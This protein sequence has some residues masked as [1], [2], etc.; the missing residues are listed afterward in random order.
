MNLGLKQLAGFLLM[1]VALSGCNAL[2]RIENI[3]GVPGM[4]PITDPTLDPNYKPV[5]MPIPPTSGIH[6]A[7]SL[8]MAGSHSFFHDPRASHVGDVITVD[9]T[10]ADNAQGSNTTTRARQNADS[11]NMTNFFGLENTLPNILPGSDPSKLINMGS[12]TSN[13]GTGT[14]NRSE[15]INLTVAAIVTQVLGNGNLVITGHQQVLVNEEMRDLQVSGIVR[16]EDITMSNTVNLAQVA[17][18]RISYGGK[19]QITDF[20]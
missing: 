18:A 13:S 7:N 2:D 9:I 3:G 12:D 19:G 6:A 14:I 20:Q 17:E 10:I 5:Q 4:A 15:A 11:A 1:G 8:W 16:T